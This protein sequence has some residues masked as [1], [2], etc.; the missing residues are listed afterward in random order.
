MNYIELEEYN[1]LISTLAQHE[2]TII[3]MY[4][5]DKPKKNILKIIR[6]YIKDH[7][8]QNEVLN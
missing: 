4:A 3:L 6:E 7:E 8:W 5:K 1:L 2:K